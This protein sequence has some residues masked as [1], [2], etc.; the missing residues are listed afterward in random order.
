MNTGGA[1]SGQ[2]WAGGAGGGREGYISQGGSNTRH[3]TPY[4]LVIVVF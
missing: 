4:T 1:R 3:I 2:E